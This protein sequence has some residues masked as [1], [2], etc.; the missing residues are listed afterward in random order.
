MQLGE[1]EN[2]FLGEAALLEVFSSLPGTTVK[3]G[4][5]NDFPFET[6]GS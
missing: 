2:C 5:K 1:I 3:I 6:F 4:G